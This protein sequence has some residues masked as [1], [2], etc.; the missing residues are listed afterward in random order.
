MVFS[1]G[2]PSKSSDVASAFK[3]LLTALMLMAVQEGRLASPDDKV[4]AVEPRLKE[5]NDGKD[6]GIT[7]RHLAFQLSGYGLSE[8]AGQ[9]Y[10]YNDYAITLYYDTL[11]TKVF[12]TNGTEVLRTRL[13]DSLQ[14]E[15]RYTF[16]AFG[17]NDRPGR[18]ALS[19]RDFARFGL[20]CLR[21]GKWHDRQIL[22][23]DL[24][25]MAMSSPLP[26]ETPLSS[27]KTAE[28]LPRQ[29]TLG[30]RLNITPVGPG[31]YSFNWWLNGTNGQGQRLFPS[32]PSDVVVA[33]GHG[34]MRVLY[35]VP[36]E[37]LIVCWNDSGIE[38]HDRSPGNPGTRMNQAAKL[39]QEAITAPD[40]PSGDGKTVRGPSLGI[41][42]PRFTINNRETFLFGLSY[43]GALG[44]RKEF[45]EAD[46]DDAL[47]HGFNWIRIWAN[48][49]AF[50]ADAAAVD[51]D[52]N[53]IQ[54][55]M[56]RLKSLLDECA[57]RNLL[58]DISLSRGNGVSGPPRLQ[59]L[60][61]HQRAVENLV[62]ELKPWRN[63][64]LD[65]SNERNIRDKRFAPFE[66]LAVLRRRVRELDPQR[67]VTASQGGDIS[68]G[69]V[70]SY[71]R[72]VGVDFLA[73]HRPRSKD[74]PATMQAETRRLLEWCARAGRVIP[75]HHQEPFRR[76]YDT[77]QPS[78]RDFQLDLEAA[79][80]GGAAGWCFHN[81]DQRKA[82]D[83]R[84]RRSFD[85]REQRLFDQFDAEEKAF[86]KT[87]LGR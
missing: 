75:V 27:G 86:L 51:G 82:D 69:E 81:G 31:Y 19:C 79:R 60:A 32:A 14:F 70:E 6:G 49:R 47:R 54:E 84:P 11:M 63:W 16:N 36:S 5:L 45:R 21:G 15:D 37:D 73:P 22:R 28:M 40:S 34:G 85:L 25:R 52:G 43:Y 33:S 68:Q 18:L 24:V 23:E 53:V 59:S 42:G 56:A 4:A 83:G 9:A 3:P 74:A 48:W 29:R 61:A 78:A 2:D 20:L 10:S 26:A 17:T 77:W 41:S 58:V 12:L 67:L 76:G 50:G 72:E 87:L 66:D 39:I 30:G 8:R 55:G 35:L 1:W 46:L 7:W 13:A 38:D 44:A 62:N 57:V 71:V 80:Q 64:Y 65:L